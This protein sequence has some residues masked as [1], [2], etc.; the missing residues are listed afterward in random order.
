AMGGLM[1][2]CGQAGGPPTW[3]GVALGDV[4]SGMNAANAIAVALFQR[5]RTGRGTYLDIS[6][7]DS[8]VALAERS[9]SAYS[10][11]GHILQ[12]GVE[13]YMAPWGPFRT[14]DGWVALVV[15]TER[16]WAKFCEAM[17]RPDLVGTEQTS[18]G[19]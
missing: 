11:T 19:P 13:P 4:V 12:R 18:S 8:M 14:K 9:V 6:M 3:L 1:N 16:D 2:T 10:L 15:A 7:Y 5:E 17:E